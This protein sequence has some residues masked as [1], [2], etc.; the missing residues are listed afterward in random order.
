MRAKDPKQIIPLI[1][2]MVFPVPWLDS[3][4]ADGRTNREQQTEVSG[5]LIASQFDD[6]RSHTNS[7]VYLTRMLAT[8]AQ[9]GVGHISQMGAGLGHRV[10]AT[11]LA[12]IARTI[13]KVTIVTGDEDHLVDP[14]NS[15][16]VAS[17]MPVSHSCD[18][19]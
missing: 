18:S 8:R 5:P 1:L 14:R 17:C 12:R 6:P 16:W 10:T 7:Q 4:A 11:R 3:V 19:E 13:P 9:S 2:E 15:E